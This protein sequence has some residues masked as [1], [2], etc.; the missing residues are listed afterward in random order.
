MVETY[1]PPFKR[2]VSQGKPAQVMCAYNSINGTPAC[3]HGDLQNGVLRDKWGF[4]GLIVSD[5]DS[6]ADAWKTHHY[7]GSQANASALA[8]KAG[9]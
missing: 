4:D 2:C 5:Q 8:V 1:L 9:T 3:L 6:V 7:G